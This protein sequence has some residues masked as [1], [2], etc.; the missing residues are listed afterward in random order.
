[1][2][3][4]MNLHTVIAHPYLPGEKKPP[5]I[6][7]SIRL[8]DG[9][10]FADAMRATM[11]LA[12]QKVKNPTM[13]RYAVERVVI[14]IE[15]DLMLGIVSYLLKKISGLLWGRGMRTAKGGA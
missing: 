5:D 9:E 14:P 2:K 13:P 1:M 7:V 12:E 6:R 11:E 15:V 8:S 4:N 10:A 3:L